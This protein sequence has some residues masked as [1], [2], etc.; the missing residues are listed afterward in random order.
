M[1]EEILA[2]GIR[3][4]CGDCREVLPT[5]GKV[6]AVVTDPPYGIG[7][8]LVKG[9]RGG[10]FERLIAANAAAWDFVPAR[11]TFDA[12]RAISS[13]QI[14]WGGNYF[15]L[16]PTRK[17]LCWNKLRPNQKNLS[18]WEMAWT[19]LEGRAQMFTHCAN[20]GFVTP[21]PN[22]HPTQ[23]PVPLMEWCLYLLPDAATIL[24]P[25]M[26]SGTTGIAAVKLGRKFI[27]IEIDERYFSIAC[28]RI[29]EALNKPDLFIKKPAPAIQAAFE[30]DAADDF[31]KSLTVG[32]DAIRERV[33]NGGPGW[34]QRTEQEADELA[35]NGRNTGGKN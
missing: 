8:A 24:D 23:K 1:R 9:G 7:D 19:S 21:E 4:I 29:S 34:E 3:L 10:S 32:Y 12:I 31:A 28:R 15:D 20:G 30:Y 6:D 35:D 33:A 25:F 17:P 2:D 27:G 5:L 22:E 11:D 13:D 26:G 18:E 14:F 16:P